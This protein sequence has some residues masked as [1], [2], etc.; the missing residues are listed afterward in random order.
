[1]RKYQHFDLGGVLYNMPINIGVLRQMTE[2]V[3]DPFQMAVSESAGRLS[4]LKIV[5]VL[6]IGCRAAEPDGLSEDALATLIVQRGVIESVPD[7][8]SYLSALTTSG[9]APL[10]G[11]IEGSDA[12]KSLPQS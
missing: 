2:R 7:A 9:S 11:D 10:S 1:M 12:K 8:V 3:G 6:T 5:E 4:G